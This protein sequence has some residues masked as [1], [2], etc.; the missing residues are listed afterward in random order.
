MAVRRLGKGLSALIPDTPLDE[1][2]QSERLRD[3]EVAKVSPNPFQPREN[4]DPTAL[5]ELKQSISENGITP[6]EVLSQARAMLSERPTPVRH[7][8]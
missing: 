4:F 3:V 1:P 8:D 7:G 6:E 5:Q 2:Q